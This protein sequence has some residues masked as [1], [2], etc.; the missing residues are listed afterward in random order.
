MI[1]LN[2]VIIDF[3]SSNHLLQKY[4]LKLFGEA[5]K[6]KKIEQKKIEN[7]KNKNTFRINYVK[8]FERSDFIESLICIL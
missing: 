2:R 4:P 8:S 3:L 5:K 1:L 7:K 6:K